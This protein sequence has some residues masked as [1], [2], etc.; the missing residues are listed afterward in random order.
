[1]FQL[2]ILAQVSESVIL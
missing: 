1:M 2:S